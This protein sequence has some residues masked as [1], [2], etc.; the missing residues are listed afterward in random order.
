MKV[1]NT[2][3]IDRREI[4]VREKEKSEARSLR[5]DWRQGGEAKSCPNKMWGYWKLGLQEEVGRFS[6]RAKTFLASILTSQ[7][8]V[9]CPQFFSSLYCRSQGKYMPRFKGQ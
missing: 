3:I 4:L 9:S 2:N 8:V 6:H 7:I 1:T 5:Q